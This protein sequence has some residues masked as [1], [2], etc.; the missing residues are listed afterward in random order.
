ME[1]ETLLKQLGSIS[2]TY[3]LEAADIASSE[4]PERQERRGSV[5]FRLRTSPLPAVCLGFV[6][7]LVVIAAIVRAS[8]TSPETPEGT[9]G[10]LPGASLS[11]TDL[12]YTPPVDAPEEDAELIAQGYT[13]QIGRIVRHTGGYFFVW[14]DSSGRWDFT[15]LTKGFGQTDAIPDDLNNGDLVRVYYQYIQKTY[16]SS[17]PV[18]RA[19]LLQRGQLDLVD[20]AT[21]GNIM[22]LSGDMEMGAGWAI[23]FDNIQTG[24][25]YRM[26]NEWFL[27]REDKDGNQTGYC[28]LR[29]VSW[30]DLGLADDFQT[31]DR[32]EVSG[33]FFY[34]TDPPILPTYR[35]TLLERGDESDIDPDILRKLTDW[36]DLKLEGGTLPPFESA[37]EPETEPKNEPET[38]PLPTGYTKTVG[39]I[40]RRTNGS[41]YLISEDGGS[42]VCIGSAL[43]GVNVIPD[44]LHNGDLVRVYHMGL[45]ESY[46]VQM[47]VYRLDLIREG[48]LTEITNIKSV[49][50][51]IIT[52]IEFDVD[53]TGRLYRDEANDLW[54]LFWT[55]DEGHTTGRF[56]LLYDYLVADAD[57]ANFQTGDLV[58][59]SGDNYLESDPPILPA[60]YMTL[61][62]RGDKNDIDPEHLAWLINYP[63]E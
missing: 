49:L 24:R 37:T 11:G 40:L 25:L 3:V 42:V 34:Y 22:V 13:A 31:G 19:E 60:F 6:V 43:S 27:I 50:N 47:P 10:R 7:A 53:V 5:W 28:Y 56:N 29:S 54:Y 59:V 38:E 26:G 1:R 32:V 45:L 14:Q 30:L 41:Y 23:C 2:E 44:D 52:G 39:R 16:P 20:G 61:L 15:V 33:G 58:T 36:G 12:I 62:E 35:V 55:D 18:Y 8:W 17:M 57:F 51:R 46:P 21:L 63:T 48:T 9:E 4:R